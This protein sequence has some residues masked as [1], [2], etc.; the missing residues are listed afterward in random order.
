MAQWW[1]H[2]MTT[3]ERS[4]AS[5]DLTYEV[6]DVGQREV[7]EGFHAAK[8]GVRESVRS[9]SARAVLDR[10]DTVSVREYIDLIADA[11][12]F[13]ERGTF[14]V[15]AR[16][17]DR[18]TTAGDGKIGGHVRVHDRPA[19]LVGDDVT[20]KRATTATMGSRKKKR[21]LAH[22]LRQGCPIVLLGSSAGARIPDVLGAEGVTELEMD[23]LSATRQRKVPMI[24]VITGNSFGGSS[25]AAAHS[26]IVIQVKNAAMSITSPRL[27]EVAIGEKVTTD[28][29]GGQEVHLS[30]TG[31]SDIGAES[32]A[33]AAR[34]VRELLDILPP[35][36]M[37]VP[38]RQ[39]FDETSLVDPALIDEVPSRSRRAYDM[40]KVIRRLADGEHF[41]EIQP[42]FG[43]PV[44]TVM[45]R[46]GGFSVGIVASQPLHQAGALDADSCDK[47]VRFITLCEANNMP[48]IFL[49]DQPGFL[50]G[51]RVEHDRLLAKA[52][53]MQQAI[54]LS[55]MP[56]LTVVLRKAFGFGYFALGGAFDLVDGLYAWPGA[57]FGFM[58]QKAGAQV[59]V[60]ADLSGASGST[61]RE[62][63]EEGSEDFETEF[64]AYVPARRMRVDEVI[65]PAETKRVLVNDLERL[66]P[67]AFNLNGSR[68]LLSWPTRW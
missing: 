9:P 64:D 4:A 50:V 7:L 61:R 45:A 46:L 27:I 16:P 47:V 60:G 3:A 63:L 53:M 43:R 10:L 26:D 48:L 49:Q 15:S 51:S 56:K 31:Q 59:V 37:T 32:P 20:V 42:D 6:R 22:A 44:I 54:A 14:V 38:E 36:A 12:S 58:D 23:R 29:L 41:V 62:A 11:N 30:K 17:E 39:P 5:D 8:A 25:F 67:H 18:E 28:E 13:E 52:I 19:V 1:V 40:H 24:S 35:N 66:V 33:D 34:I 21:L 2:E 68:P 55:T 57:T 65:D